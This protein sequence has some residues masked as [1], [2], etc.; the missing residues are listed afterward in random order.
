MSPWESMIKHQ[1]PCHFY[2]GASQM[3]VFARCC[4]WHHAMPGQRRSDSTPCMGGCRPVELK[5][6]YQARCKSPEGEA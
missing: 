1:S 6:L 5:K 4:L 2:S 3:P